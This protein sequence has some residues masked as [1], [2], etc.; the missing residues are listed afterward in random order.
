[1]PEP[2]TAHL[3]GGPYHDRV[4]T[5]KRPYDPLIFDLEDWPQAVYRAVHAAVPSRTIAF[6][7]VGE[8]YDDGL[9]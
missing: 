3:I 9:G 4:I 8:R 2:V 1:M 7:Y 6:M 5:L